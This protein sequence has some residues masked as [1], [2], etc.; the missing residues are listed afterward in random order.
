MSEEG[1]KF[2]S[3]DIYQTKAGVGAQ[4]FSNQL[5]QKPQK[6]HKSRKFNFN[7]N[8]KLLRRILTIA[9]IVLILAVAAFAIYSIINKSIES[10]RQAQQPQQLQEFREVTSQKD[11]ERGRETCYNNG[12]CV[13][14]S[15]EEITQMKESN[16]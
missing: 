10:D 15:T 1:N 9:I 11:T 13:V 16:E 8:P 12:I 4:Y 6:P 5:D 7:I 14:Q 3:T 2:K